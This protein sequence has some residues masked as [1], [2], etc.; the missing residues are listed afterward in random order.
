MAR[1]QWLQVRVSAEEKARVR[2][3][4]AQSGLDESA[5][6]R[7]RVLEDLPGSP[8]DRAM[9]DALPTEFDGRDG[10][11]EFQKC[12]PEPGLFARTDGLPAALRGHS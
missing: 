1:D 7:S 5:F 6:V 4:A 11:V 2:E 12:P 10:R 9:L 3:L 8:M